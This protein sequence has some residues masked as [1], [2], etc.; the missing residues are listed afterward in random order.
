[1]I[2]YLDLLLAG[3]LPLGGYLIF[4]R[5]LSKYRYI[6][7][8]R[9]AEIAPP[10]ETP[11]NSFKVYRLDPEGGLASVTNLNDG[12]LAA[13]YVRQEQAQGMSGRLYNKGQMV[14]EW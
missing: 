13:A 4:N 7:L 14:K 11:K 9:K 10:D 5:Y 12:G 3:I 2:E 8:K 6:R 1:M